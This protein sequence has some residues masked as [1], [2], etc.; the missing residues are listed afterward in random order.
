MKKIFYPF[1][2]SCRRNKRHARESKLIDRLRFAQY[3]VLCREKISGSK[4]PGIGNDASENITISLTSYGPRIETVYLTIESLMQQS[5]KADRIVLCLAKSEFSEKNLPAALKHQR[6]RG[7][8]ILFCEEDLRSYKKFF[9]TLQKYPQDLIITADDDLIYPIDTVDLLYRAYLEEPGVI[10]CNRAHQMLLDSQGKLCP[11]K[12]WNWGYAASESS[13]DTFPTGVGG[14]LYFPGSLDEAV[15]DKESFLRLAPNSDDVWL[16]A[17]SLKKSVKCRQIQSCFSFMERAI[18]IPG[19]QI[20]SLKRKN[21]HD[22]DGNDLAVS[23]IFGEYNLHEAVK[24]VTVK[25]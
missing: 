17:M 10:H 9:Y 16:K 11:Y 25:R 12:Q 18:E 8:E 13:F 20:V 23:R 7:L 2:K 4:V 5:F 1:T 3:E 22:R 21:K 14:V 15:L 19:S 24:A 6:E